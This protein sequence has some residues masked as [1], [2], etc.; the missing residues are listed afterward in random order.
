[1]AA[2]DTLLNVLLVD[3]EPFIRKG[4]TALIDW[5]AEG[6]RIAGEAS[7]GR[8]AIQMLNAKE[9]D[10]ILS[11]I[12]MPEMDGIEFISYVRSNK[13]GSARFVFLSGF[14]DFQYAKTG[15][16]Y[17]CCDYI[18]KP[19]QKEELLST[20]RRIMEAYQRDASRAMDS[21]VYEKAYLDRNLMSLIW[22][23]YDNV[24]L[25]Y[26]TMKLKLT[27]KVS[28]LHL[29]IS[30]RDETFLILTDDKRRE[31]QRKLYHYAGLLLKD[32]ANHIIF[33]V[34]KNDDCYDVGIIYSDSFASDRELSQ[35]EWIEWLVMELKERIGY[36]IEAC[37][38]RK[39]DS[40]GF[41]SESYR[42]ACMIR[43][44]RFTGKH[45]N[46]PV[47]VLCK[48]D[49]NAKNV[50]QEYLRKE[51][52]DLIHSI[53][54]GDILKLR[55]NVSIIY[56]R[57]IDPHI[58]SEVIGMNIQYLLYRLMGLAY[59]LDANINQ[60][61]IIHYM[62]DSIFSSDKI[63]GNELKF[64]QFVEEYTEYLTQLRQNTAKGTI[65]QIEAEIENHYSENISLK[66]LG[67]KYYINSAYLGQLFKKNY[68]CCFKD[69]LNGIRMRKAAET[70]LRTNKKIYEIAEEVGYKNIEYFINKFEDIYGMTPSRFRKKN[71]NG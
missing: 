24:N 53:E 23:K 65:N 41:I 58:E 11:D 54:I 43:F 61:E 38:G 45:E 66:Y 39:V 25:N 5:E 12:K 7:N 71:L 51:L 37:I 16:Q 26:V 8:N 32:R 62:K 69:Y 15:M 55:K 35:N 28:Y 31:R 48:K 64:L 33:D 70:M 56:G 44:F 57:M 6:Y 42:E 29:E 36:A 2:D 27:E 68:G 20:L 4:L 46:N 50:Q 30:L 10:V 67:E 14:Y 49:M 63:A 17:G 22:G 34:T 59:A 9:F 18:L 40:I 3:D 60:D 13:L 1:M 52:D 19:I 47:P 21:K